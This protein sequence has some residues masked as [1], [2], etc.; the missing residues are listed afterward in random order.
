MM[1]PLLF[2]SLFVNSPRFPHLPKFRT[3]PSNIRYRAHTMV[4]LPVPL[5]PRRKFKFGLKL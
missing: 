1:V 4:L 5:A 2:L 3:F